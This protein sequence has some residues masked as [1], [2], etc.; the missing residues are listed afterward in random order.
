MVR[1]VFVSENVENVNGM[2]WCKWES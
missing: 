2:K 1:Q